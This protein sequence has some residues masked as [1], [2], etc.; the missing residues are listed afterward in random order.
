M[1]AREVLL[2]GGPEDGLRLAVSDGV[3]RVVFPEMEPVDAHVLRAGEAPRP[4]DPIGF[5]EHVYSWRGVI[6]DD[7]AYLLLY[8]G[9]RGVPR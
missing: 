5:R 7:G 8:D 6:L 3:N 2:L 4:E 1:S 9:L